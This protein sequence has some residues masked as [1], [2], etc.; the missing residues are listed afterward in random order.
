MTKSTTEECLKCAHYG[1]N[2]RATVS[3]WAWRR[4]SK[5]DRTMESSCCHP[6]SY[7]Q[8]NGRY[9]TAVGDLQEVIISSHSS[10]DLVDD[11]AVAGR[12]H[13]RGPVRRGR[14]RCCWVTSASRRR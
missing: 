14:L 13:G 5:N 4:I 8:G 9:M 7:T 12:G 2:I 3:T 1:A 11:D 10:T 6:A